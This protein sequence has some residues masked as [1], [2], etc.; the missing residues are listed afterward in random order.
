ME[1]NQEAG[2]L[3]QHN[4]MLSVAFFIVMLGVVVMS[5]VMQSVIMHRLRV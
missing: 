5:V 3:N 1:C 4:G 2:A